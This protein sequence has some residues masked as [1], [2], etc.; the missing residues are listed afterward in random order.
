MPIIARLVLLLSLWLAAPAA[1][2]RDVAPEGAS[3]WTDKPAVTARAHMVVAAHP[4]AA[5]AGD[6]VLRDGG[7]AVD[8]AI[9]TQMVLALVEPQSSGI[10]GGGFLLHWRAG[11][12][13]PT[14]YDGRETAPAAATPERFLGPDGRPL[15]F[16]DAVVGGGSV[17]VPGLLRMLEAAHAAHGRLPWARLLAPAIALA[18]DGFPMSPRLHALLAG[19]KHLAAD[20]AARAYFYGPDG[21]PLPVGTILRN[22]DFAATLRLI[23]EG[24]ADAFYRGPLAA[25][26]VAAVRTRGG[27]L[28]LADLAAYRA[29]VREALCRPYRAW[30]VCGMPPPTS[31][32]IAVLQILGILSHFDL[33][34]L[35]PLSP[36]AAHLIAEASKLAFADRNRYVADADFVDVP[37]DGLLDPDY[38][39]GRAALI[40][41]E[42]ATAKAAPGEL[43]VRRG[44]LDGVAPELPSTSHISVVDG[45]GDAV[46]FTS[47]IENAFG[48]RIMVAGFLLNNQLTDFA[49]APERAGGLV[50]NRVEPGKRPRSS[51]APTMV[52]DRD[53]RLRLVTGSPGGSR[54]I[55]YVAR[56]VIAVLDWGLDAQ[57]AAALPHVVNRNG[58]T[59]LEDGTAAEAL[60]EPLRAL[61]HVVES[62]RMTSGLHL[63]VV[64]DGVLHGGADPRREG[65][66]VGR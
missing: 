36:E 39:R 8:A 56:N 65:A 31:G 50:A 40:R 33:P 6:A 32:G 62:P 59:E 35:A 18:E 28:T 2:A 23:A 4:L 10:G 22:P 12:G 53:G 29:V 3:G 45:A 17:G 1:V 34:A 21:A 57:D 11:D 41:P 25:R 30:R 13:A 24:G 5:A 26:I 42:A 14:A 55:G 15:P 48:S 49:F 52:F 9:A 60:A 66:A 38:L 19:E 46:S 16:F 64:E 58:P 61:G 27:D 43:P 20:P 47:S 44:R 63:I 54:I 37:V 7:G 51:M